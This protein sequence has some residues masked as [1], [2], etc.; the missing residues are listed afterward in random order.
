MASKRP[1]NGRPRNPETN[2]KTQPN[3]KTMTTTTPCQKTSGRRERQDRN[4][5]TCGSTWS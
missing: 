5:T 4:G 1:L 2:S 3:R